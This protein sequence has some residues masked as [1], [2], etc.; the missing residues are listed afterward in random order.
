[1]KTKTKK[2]SQ[3]ETVSRFEGQE[4]SARTGELRAPT[5]EQK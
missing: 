3:S 4:L 5:T 1:M 2:T